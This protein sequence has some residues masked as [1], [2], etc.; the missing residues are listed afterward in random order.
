M[1]RK[2]I[3]LLV[4]TSLW[5]QVQVHIESIPPDVDVLID[6]AKAGTTPIDDLTLHPGKHSFYLEKE[7]YTI[8]HYT[9]YLVGAE[10]AVLR[11]RLKEKYSVTFK[12]DYEPLHY[13]LD[14][15][16]AWTEEKM[17]FDMEAGRHTLEVFL[18]DSLVDQQ[19]VLIRES[20]T[21]RYH[22]QGDRN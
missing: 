21:I 5:G 17:R 16:Y 3:L 18:G 20:T 15:K 12:S 4:I 2:M 9:T 1:M 6:G 7:G 14:G 10:K 13:R 11:F 19:E 8:L 22:Y